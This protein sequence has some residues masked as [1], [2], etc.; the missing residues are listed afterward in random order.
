[1]TEYQTPEIFQ[2]S[3]EDSIH[4]RMLE[5]LPENIDKSEGSV[6]WDL[7]R[8]TAIEIAQF[9]GWDMDYAIQMIFPQFA[10]GEILDYHGEARGLSRKDAIA[11]TGKLTVTGEPGAVIAEGDLFSTESVN[12]QESVSYRS[13]EYYVIPD[14]G[15]IEIEIECTETGTAGNA[16]PNTII[17]V[18][19]ANE[20]IE[21]VTNTEEVKGGV[22]EESDDE[23]RERIVESDKN[24]DASYAGTPA[25]YKRWANEVSGVG[26]VSVIAAQ[27]TTG[28]VTLI[29]TDGNGNPANSTLCEAVYNHIM[30]PDDEDQRLAPVNTVL[31]VQAP[32]SIA[33]TVTADIELSESNIEIVTAAFS[34]ALKTYLHSSID[35]GEIRYTKI[36]NILG[37]TAGV[38]DY[39]NLKVNGSTEN[40]TLT[41][42]ELPTVGTI[43]LTAV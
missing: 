36:S 34:E 30:S 29:I 22:D 43:T 20:Q 2:D 19:T 31:V 1:M 11:A 27:D 6:V 38:Y 33:I 12:D 23:Y 35:D 21:S 14:S 37:D 41:S 28:T 39:T 25:D 15:T 7:T 32:S 26:S 13:K 18:E 9:K 8:P 4:E 3:D 24:K 17:L 42:K 16:I 40:I 10:F 5:V